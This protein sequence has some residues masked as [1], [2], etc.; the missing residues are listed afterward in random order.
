MVGGWRSA[1]AIQ[2]TA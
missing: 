2:S 1:D